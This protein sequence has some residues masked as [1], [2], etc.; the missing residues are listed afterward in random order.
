MSSEK[1]AKRPMFRTFTGSITAMRALLAFLSS[2]H[3]AEW[4]LEVIDNAEAAGVGQAKD[5]A[6]AIRYAAKDIR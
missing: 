6:D 5:L 3:N 1:Q 2:T 4:I